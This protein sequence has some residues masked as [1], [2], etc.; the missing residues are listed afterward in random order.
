M[1]ASKG[2]ILLVT[3]LF[4]Y[5]PVRGIELRIIK[6]IR[7][8]GSEGYKVVLVVSGEPAAKPADLDELR[9]LVHRVHWEAPALRT[10]VGRSFPGLRRVVWENVKPLFAPPRP[11]RNGANGTPGTIPS[12][13]GDEA[14]KRGV[15]SPQFAQMVSKLAGK[16]KPLAVIAE[17]IF[18]T[19]CFPLLRANVFKIIDTSDVFSLKENQVVSYGIDDPWICTPEEERAYLSRADALIAIQAEE[20]AVLRKLAPEKEVIKVG[21]DFDVDNLRNTED[22]DRNRILVIGSD[23]PLNVHGLR[24]FFED[25]WPAIKQANPAVKLDVVGLVGALC[26]I[27]DLAVN[28]IERADDLTALYRRARIVINPTVA[29]TGLKIKSVEALAHGRPLVAWPHGVDGLSY[30]DTAPYVKC[31]TWEE[32]AQAVI[33]LLRS[34]AE[35]RALGERA[36]QYAETEFAA[37]RVYAPLKTLLDRISQARM[38]KTGSPVSS[39]A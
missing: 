36:L 26:R 38:L 25:C 5:P 21:V 8:L 6:L 20:A 35:A 16:Y 19:D 24:S 28:Y 34:D 7:W 12:A 10:R 11:V 27:E 23:N 31:Q 18:L 3:H 39:A 29:G 17:Y 1:N 37:E 15:S 4:P 32:F 30:T 9:K 22:V 33:L 14:K 13:V 2:Y